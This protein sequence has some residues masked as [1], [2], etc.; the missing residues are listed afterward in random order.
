MA[1]R[2]GSL[3]RRSLVSAE[4]FSERAICF[5]SRPA[6]TPDSRSSASLV[7]VTRCDHRRLVVFAMRSGRQ[8]PCPERKQKAAQGGLCACKLRGPSP[9]LVGHLARLRGL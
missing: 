7:A 3:L 6:N 5:A 4:R 8:A 9:R 2:N 1:E